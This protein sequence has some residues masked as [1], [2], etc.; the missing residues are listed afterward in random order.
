VGNVI[1]EPSTA[2]L[3]GMGLLAIGLQTRSR[4]RQPI[5]S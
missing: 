5:G 4:Y 3:L 2:L 1:P